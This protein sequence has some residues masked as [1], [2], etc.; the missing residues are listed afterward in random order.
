MQSEEQW[1]GGRVEKEGEGKG[2]DRG[3]PKRQELSH[4]KGVSSHPLKG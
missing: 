1:G 2:R 4:W 3:R